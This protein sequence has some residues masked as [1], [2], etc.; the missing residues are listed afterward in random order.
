MISRKP[1]GI[2]RSLFAFAAVALFSLSGASELAAQ[3]NWKTPKLGDIIR[4]KKIG[5]DFRYGL[6]VENQTIGRVEYLNDDQDIDRDTITPQTEW[7]VVDSFSK[8][9]AAVSRVWKSE[10]GKFELKAKLHRVVGKSVQLEKPNGKTI[11]VA[12]DKLSAKD[13]EF[14]AGRKPGKSGSANPF[15]TNESEEVPVKVVLLRERRTELMEQ[16][17][18]HL[19][20][21]KFNSELMIGDIIKFEDFRET[22]FGIVTN[23]DRLGKVEAADDGGDLDDVPLL[24]IKNWQFYDRE[25]VAMPLEHRTWK[26]S[27]GKFNVKAKLI[28]IDGDS[29]KLE[30]PDGKTTTVALSQLSKLDKNYVKRSRKRIEV[31][32]DDGLKRERENYSDALKRLLVRRD[33]IIKREISNRVVA[34]AAN[35]MKNLRLNTKP[36]ELSAERLKPMSLPDNADFN[37]SFP[38]RVAKSASLGKIC[39]AP[40]ANLVAFAAS[41]PFRGVPTLTVVDVASQ[42]VTTSIDSDEVGHDGEVVALSPS[43]RTLIVCS[44]EIRDRQLELWNYVDERLTR[45]NL[46]SY[47]SFHTP[48]GHLFN[49]QQGVIQNSDGD[50]VF[51]DVSDTITPTHQIEA[52]RS[53]LKPR[54]QIANDGKSVFY[55]DSKASKLHIID[56]ESRQCVGGLSLPSADPDGTV[57]YINADG[58]SLSCVQDT[59]L[60]LISFESGKTIDEHGMNK[61]ESGRTTAAAKLPGSL[62]SRLGRFQYLGSGIL[63]SGRS[64]VNLDL[65]LT[66]GHVTGGYK[67]SVS[68]YANAARI[69]GNFD[70]F[71]GSVRDATEIMTAMT[72]GDAKSRRNL[73]RSMRSKSEYSEVKTE[74]QVQRL[75]VDEIITHAKSITEEDIVD[76]G[77]NDQ[78][79]LKF[80]LGKNQSSLE[81]KLTNQIK[82]VMSK[83]GIELVDESDFVLELE[84]R[85][86]E[87]QVQIYEIY[88]DGKPRTRKVTRTPKTCSAR[89][90][91]RGES[92]W[93]RS[94]SASLD[95][96]RDEG[97]LDQMLS[98]SNKISART[99]TEFEYPT[100][101]RVVVP[102][103]RRDFSWR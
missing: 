73:R 54:I 83:V 22:R 30:K 33:E 58:K 39:Y 20:L 42:T 70:R 63:I 90:L 35:K 55:I 1:S 76:F 28:A 100:A 82:D 68:N 93:A 92:I 11:T 78:L 8:K 67:S 91:Y 12:I 7:E 24:R 98:D 89:L 16:Q 29:L 44:G 32:N 80:K 81:Q 15:E 13:Q 2:F 46:I 52:I 66:V 47:K 102:N 25:F 101:V 40:K 17:Q 56:V 96:P 5:G 6:V 21:A 41:S 64:V 62:T 71:G 50:V 57:A 43:G 53:K 74:I 10:D 34:K 86:G 36:I 23:L 72:E 3:R 103:K 59:G 4:Y 27:N 14:I 97:D 79:Q 45:K 37:L 26:S 75:A 19:R 18:R 60:K 9:P 49:D 61:P 95:R 84:Y 88:G 77:K 94:R 69:V 38:L 51:F 31:S 99:L 65:G 87:P 48:T 85:V